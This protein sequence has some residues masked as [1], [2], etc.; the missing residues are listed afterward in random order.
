M[1]KYMVRIVLG[2]TVFTIGPV[3]S[4]LIA[5]IIPGN[6]IHLALVLTPLWVLIGAV[7]GV[8]GT[9]I[10]IGGLNAD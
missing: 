5:W 3:V 8:I 1:P 10:L 9:Q 6:S 2:I 4:A 7:F